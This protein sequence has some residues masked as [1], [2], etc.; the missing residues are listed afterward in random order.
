MN[1]TPEQL[2]RHN[3]DEMLIASGWVV[4]SKKQVNLNANICVAVREYQTDVGP[5][6]YILFVNNKP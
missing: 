5:A 4:Q 2:V 3:I 6:Y 1:Q